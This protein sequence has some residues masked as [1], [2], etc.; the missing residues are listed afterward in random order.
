ML[1]RKKQEISSRK[2]IG[3]RDR[4]WGCFQSRFH[5]LVNKSLVVWRLQA[6]GTLFLF[7]YLFSPVCD[8]LVN[9]LQK[10]TSKSPDIRFYLHFFRSGIRAWWAK[11]AY[12]VMLTIRGRLITP[13]ILGSMSV[14]LN[15][16]IRHSFTDLWVWITAWVP[17]PQLLQITMEPFALFYHSFLLWCFT[18]EAEDPYAD[19]I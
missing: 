15:I 12:Q 5:A 1:T 3:S 14:G 9:L 13:F 11:L 6:Y 19:R 4:Q 2:T 10:L 8:F 7:V 17:L 18:A 16:L